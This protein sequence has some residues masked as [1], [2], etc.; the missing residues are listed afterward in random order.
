MTTGPRLEAR[1]LSIRAG[2]TAILDRV[3]LDLAPGHLRVVVGPN[4]AGKSTL[5]RALLGLLPPDGGTVQL[6][7]VEVS[8]LSP[9]Q[10]A[11]ALGWLP[12]R[13]GVRE[14]LR[15]RE[16]VATGRH[17]LGAAWSD[18]LQAAGD[19]LA[20]VDAGHLADRDATTLSGGE[21]QRVALATL[22]A[23]D[24][25][26]LLLDEPGNHLDPA[27]RGLVDRFVDRRLAEG[28]GVVVVTHDL[29]RI[30]RPAPSGVPVEVVGLRDGRRAFA[31]DPHDAGL[32]EALSALFGVRVVALPHAG[33]THL[34]VSETP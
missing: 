6:D 28:R 20:D 10:R 22:L 21:A 7:G 17:R 11:A 30:G 18:D 3:D 4:G 16:V 12:Q 19:A 33:R 13:A 24:P 31:L 9:R 2:D 14:A 8:R 15:V 27:V 1:G 29:A 34:V 25:S 5:L 26:L 23:Q 32:P